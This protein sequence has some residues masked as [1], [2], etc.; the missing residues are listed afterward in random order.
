M[1]WIKEQNGKWTHAEL[2]VIQ[3]LPNG[4]FQVT[5]PAGEIVDAFETVE[6]AM[7]YQGELWTGWL[8][9]G[10]NAWAHP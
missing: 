2:G 10:D 8:E 6:Q 5:N 7:V 3:C 9:A 1:Q 4:T